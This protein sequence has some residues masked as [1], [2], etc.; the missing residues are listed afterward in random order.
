MKRFVT[1]RHFN[2][3]TV[4]AR[5]NGRVEAAHESRRHP[6]PGGSQARRDRCSAASHG[7]ADDLEQ[8][9]RGT[10]RAV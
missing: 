3:A 7:R 8:P 4:G 1:G 2:E 9:E 6:P 10:R 5:A